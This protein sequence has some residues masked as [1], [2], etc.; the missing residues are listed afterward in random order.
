MVEEFEKDCDL[1]AAKTRADYRP[2]LELKSNWLVKKAITEVMERNG[3]E[4]QVTHSDLLRRLQ[5]WYDSDITQTVGL[6]KEELQKLDPEIRKLI[7]KYRYKKRRFKQD[8][9]W[10][11]EEYFECEFVS[12]EK[13]LDMVARHIGFFVKDN[14]E[15]QIQFDMKELSDNAMGELRK[16]LTNGG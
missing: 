8:G 15:A 14:V 1:A 6:T 7:T 9:E 12:K 16:M 10:V 11:V 13:A 5:K 2:N 3:K 4:I